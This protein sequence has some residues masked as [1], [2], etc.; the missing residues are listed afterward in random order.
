MRSL[1]GQGM[2]RHGTA[3]HSSAMPG[4]ARQC[5]AGHGKVYFFGEQNWHCAA[6]QG[7]ARPGAAGRGQALQ[8]KA[9]NSYAAE[10]AGAH[11]G[12]FMS[13]EIRFDSLLRHNVA[14]LGPAGRGEARRS[15]ARRG[16]A[17]STSGEM[18]L[19]SR[20][21]NAGLSRALRGAARRFKARSTSFGGRNLKKFSRHGMALY[22]EAMHSAA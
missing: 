6:L 16:T 20:R 14:W 2:A 13:K 18:K 4:S 19:E 5:I 12:S 15:R 1:A 21:G 17:R 7:D 8:G 10:R 11:L 9:R 3:R 22:G